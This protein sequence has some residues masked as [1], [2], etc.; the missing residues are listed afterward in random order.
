MCII[1]AFI[2]MALR[3]IYVEC[4]YQLQAMQ[5]WNLL[6]CYMIPTS[7]ILNVQY[8]CTV[9]NNHCLNIMYII[10]WPIHFIPC[11]TMQIL[12]NKIKLSYMN[13]NKLHKQQSK[14]IKL[15]SMLT[16]NMYAVANRFWIL[17][18]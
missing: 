12:E 16:I 17:F 13:K 10:I 14:P 9:K 4:S 7:A 3:F 1:Y 5:I 6:H 2:C 8:I 18:T 11:K 15:L